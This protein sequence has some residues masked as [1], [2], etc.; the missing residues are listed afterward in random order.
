M[1]STT[2]SATAI[3]TSLEAAGFCVAFMSYTQYICTMQ[4]INAADKLPTPATVP[5][6]PQSV[7]IIAFQDFAG[8]LRLRYMGKIAPVPVL[9]EFLNG[10]SR[11]RLQ[12]ILL[13]AASA[14]RIE[15]VGG[16]SKKLLA[17]FSGLGKYGYNT[18]CYVDGFG[19]FC[20]LDAYYTD[21]P[22]KENDREY[23][24]TSMDTCASCG[25]CIKNCATGALEKP[26]TVNSVNCLYSLNSKTDPIPEW[27]PPAVH[28]A[29]MGCI[30]CQEVCPINKKTPAPML[31][32]LELDESESDAL[33][34][35]PADELPTGLIQKLSNYG[36][37]RHLIS[38]A[39][40]NARL[41][42]EA[43]GLC[44]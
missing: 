8:E 27:V 29:M 31:Q 33:L 15:G 30:R 2:N 36:L 39:G 22:C 10:S 44:D 17:S 40:R 35:I 6:E 12:D 21:I 23:E 13:D 20:S 9:P 43:K 37:S 25:R 18:L 14:F 7:L 19:S 32:A 34:S 1:N 3:K 5:F 24:I 28:H 42:I 26:Y 41:V 4:R 16:V 11:Q 38:V